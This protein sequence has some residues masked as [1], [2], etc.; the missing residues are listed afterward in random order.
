[1]KTPKRVKL[2]ELLEVLSFYADKKNHCEYGYLRDIPIDTDRGLKARKILK[3]IV[4]EYIEQYN[5]GKI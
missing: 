2:S 5:K 1:M 4:N 3:K